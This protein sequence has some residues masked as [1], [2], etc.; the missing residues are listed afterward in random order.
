MNPKRDEPALGSIRRNRVKSTG[1][2]ESASKVGGSKVD[3][4]R[5]GH[6]KPTAAADFL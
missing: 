4:A 3:V 1:Q 6:G 5:P 2:R